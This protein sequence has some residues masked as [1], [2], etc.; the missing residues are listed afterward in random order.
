MG[1]EFMLLLL[2]GSMLIL[3]ATGMPIAFSF[4][5]VVIVGAYVFFGGTVGLEQLILSIYSSLARFVLL[6][7][8]LFIFMGELMSQSGIGLKVI[9]ALNK[10]LG[11]LPGRLSLLAVGAGTLLS[12]LTGASLASTAILGS[13]LV[14]EME[15]RGYKKPMSLGPVLGSGGL[16][17]MI[18]PSGL[19]IILGAIGEI[20]IG[21]ILIAIM[22]PGL[23]MACFYATYIL[24]ACWFKPSL[25]PS[26]EV[27]SSSL[28]EKLVGLVLYVLPTGVIVFLVV[29]LIFMGVAT[30][31][32]S[33][34]SGTI[35][36]VVLL[37]FYKRLNWEVVKNVLT[38]SLRIAGMVYLIIAAALGFSEILSFSGATQGLMEFAMRLHLPDIL[39]VVIMQIIILIM[40]GFLDP[41]GIMMITLPVFVPFIVSL[42]FDPVWFATIVLL[43]IEMAM[44]TPPFG[45]CLF[46]MKGVVT[47]D[48]TMGDIYLAVFPFLA[49]DLIVMALIIVF[50]SLAVWLPRLTG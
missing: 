29:G 22:I 20:S 34:A 39:F 41:V 21:K 10:L 8:V 28:S 17:I 25:A 19:A 33:A 27:S 31:S 42:G 15:R 37:L 46:V 3:M 4:L 48:T 50:P 12:T 11:R 9:D 26:Y 24:L 40:G 30:P 43:N 6:P 5:L 47:E 44:V 32:E 49:C 16:A 18:P 2:I 7:I 14:P 36:M 13:V 38:G 23:L 1:W 35:G 45:M